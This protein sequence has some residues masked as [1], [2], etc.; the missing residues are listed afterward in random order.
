MISQSKQQ[1]SD[2]DIRPTDGHSYK[3]YTHQVGLVLQKANRRERT[4]Q[5]RKQMDT[6]ASEMG[7]PRQVETS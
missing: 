5:P 2:D 6:I 3:D 7:H 4:V 1:G